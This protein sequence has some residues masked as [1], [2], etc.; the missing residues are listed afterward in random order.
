MEHRQRPGGN[1]EFYTFKESKYGINVHMNTDR[2]HIR[3]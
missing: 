3:T 2:T 1:K